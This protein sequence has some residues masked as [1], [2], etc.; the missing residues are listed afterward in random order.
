MAKLKI[1]LFEKKYTAEDIDGKTIGRLTILHEVEPIVRKKL[2]FLTWHKKYTR[3]VLCECDCG[4][5]F[6]TDLFRV[7]NGKTQSCGCLLKE[8]RQTLHERVTPEGKAKMSEASKQR[9]N[10]PEEIERVRQMGLYNRKHEEVCDYCGKPEHYALGYCRACY[11]RFNR[12]GVVDAKEQRMARRLAEIEE[13]NEARHNKYNPT[14]ERGKELLI[15]F[16]SG[17]SLAEIGREQGVSRQRIHQ[18]MSK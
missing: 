3:R 18:I 4:N 7:M 1:S 15:K 16:Q 8:M 17:M 2:K 5:V 13:K 6:E 12:T 11:A 10:Q 14:T 9:A